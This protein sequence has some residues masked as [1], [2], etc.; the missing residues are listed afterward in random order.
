MMATL[1]AEWVNCRNA[2]NSNHEAQSTGAGVS[3][4]IFEIGTHEA[5]SVRRLVP[6]F[7]P[8]RVNLFNQLFKKFNFIIVQCYC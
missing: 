5:M 3:P 2:K 7:K 8:Q 1:P 4:G 6:A